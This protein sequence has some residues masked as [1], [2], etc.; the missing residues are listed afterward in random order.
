MDLR[1]LTEQAEELINCGNSKE[2]AEGNGMMRVI[3]EIEINNKQTIV[4]NLGDYTSGDCNPEETL[5]TLINVENKDD[6]VDN[7]I[8]ILERFEHTLLVKQLLEQIG[9]SE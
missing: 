1:L 2:I 8:T 6:M 5:A 9:Y 7:H 4:N 3:K